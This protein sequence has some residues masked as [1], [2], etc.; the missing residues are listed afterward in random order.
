MHRPRSRLGAVALALAA[1]LCGAL[2]GGWAVHA[3][4]LDPAHWRARLHAMTGADV[5]GRANAAWPMRREQHRLFVR[6]AD[7]VIIGD[8]LTHA[9]HWDDMFPAH[10]IANFGI[11]GDRTSDILRRIDEILATQ[12]KR[13][14]LMAGTNDLAAGREVPAAFAD[15]VKIVERLRAAGVEVVLQSTLACRDCGARTAQI[16][17]LNERLGAWAAEAAVRPGAPLQWLDLNASLAD[18]DGRLRA[19]LTYDGVHLNG[20]GYVAWRAAIAPRLGPR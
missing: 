15:L 18:T 20:P 7:I 5:E 19:E 16:R 17:E 3:G 4:W 14:F 11:D 10:R 2:A 6:P 12:P 9:G 8:S 1:A 13:A